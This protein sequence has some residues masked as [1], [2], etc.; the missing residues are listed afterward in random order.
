MLLVL[1][2]IFSGNIIERKCFPYL[3]LHGATHVVEL[4]A[5][6][7]ASLSL[8]QMTPLALRPPPGIRIQKT[9]SPLQSYS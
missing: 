9:R 4:A 1:G 7:R 2:G 8:E 3:E 6:H 5:R